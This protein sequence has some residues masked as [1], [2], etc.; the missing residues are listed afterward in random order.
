M[1]TKTVT[2]LRDQKA[3]RPELIPAVERLFPRLTRCN[4]VTDFC[5]LM[6]RIS[7]RGE[8]A[9]LVAYGFVTHAMLRAVPPCGQKLFDPFLRGS[10]RRVK[11]YI[12]GSTKSGLRVEVTYFH[13]QRQEL[14]ARLNAELRAVERREHLSQREARWT[15][16]GNVL[17]PVFGGA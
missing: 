12:D 10:R 9:D 8:A 5:G 7:V 6:I 11:T 16:V 15:A 3:S 17:Y 4:S 1:A 14:L 2:P 13:D